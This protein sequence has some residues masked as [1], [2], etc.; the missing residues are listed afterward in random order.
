MGVVQDH[1]TKSG[2]L[3]GKAFWSIVHQ[4]TDRESALTFGHIEKEGYKIRTQFRPERHKERQLG[5]VEIPK[6]RKIEEERAGLP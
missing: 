2:G 6:R 5:L 1:V 3:L 4:V